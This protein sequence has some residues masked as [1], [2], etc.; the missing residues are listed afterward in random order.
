MALSTNSIDL[1]KPVSQAF[2]RHEEYDLPGVKRYAAQ[3]EAESYNFR[4]S[5]NGVSLNIKKLPII[6]DLGG[7]REDR[8]HTKTLFSLESV[9]KHSAEN[10][11]EADSED[12][13]NLDLQELRIDLNTRSDPDQSTIQ[14]Q[15]AD[16]K[17]RRLPA[18]MSKIDL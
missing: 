13:Y 6:E 11:K 12:Q 9:Y 1:P 3:K 8:V 7:K 15:T 5:A 4:N 18:P 10:R 17:R 2:L 14:Q 16:D